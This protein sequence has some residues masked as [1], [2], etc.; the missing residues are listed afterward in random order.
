MFGKTSFGNIAF[1]YT[2]IK[3][4]IIF[5]N[6]QN[7]PQSIKEILISYS[8]Y[9]FWLQIPSAYST[10]NQTMLILITI[11]DRLISTQTRMLMMKFKSEI[12]IQGG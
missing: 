6:L 9:S 11:L 3:K 5:I 2:F 1:I 12:N 7:C 4:K 8:N 10:F